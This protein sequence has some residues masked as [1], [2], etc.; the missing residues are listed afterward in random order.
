VFLCKIT[1]HLDLNISKYFLCRFYFLSD[2]ELLE[3]LSQTRDP[4]AVQ[5]HLRKCFENI[6]RVCSNTLF[7]YI[8]TLIICYW[9]VKCVSHKTEISVG[10][11]SFNSSQIYRSHTCTLERGRSWSW[12]CRCIPLGTWSIGSERLRNLWRQHWVITLTAHSKFTL[13]SDTLT[14]NLNFSISNLKA[15]FNRYFIICVCCLDPSATS[16]R[17]GV[18]VAGSGGDSRLSGLLDYWGVWGFGA[19]RLNR[20][21]LPPTTDTGMG[22]MLDWLL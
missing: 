18:V 14:L 17:V 5:P 15:Y 2:D 1:R 11:L 3:I 12:P 16:Y 21:P 20:A 22:S 10:S 7:L 9:N 8:I 4:T 6:A 19:G 13:R